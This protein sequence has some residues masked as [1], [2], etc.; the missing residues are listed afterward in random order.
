MMFHLSGIIPLE[1]GFAGWVKGG[2]GK[3]EGE[4][5]IKK[6]NYDQICEIRNSMICCLEKLLMAHY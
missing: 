5:L 2:G 4:F 3:G 6:A 1:V